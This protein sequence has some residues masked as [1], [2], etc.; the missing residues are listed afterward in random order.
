MPPEMDPKEFS[1][2]LRKHILDFIQRMERDL[3]R[4]EEI[5][6]QSA[7]AF[8]RLES[9]NAKITVCLN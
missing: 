6:R 3:A 8:E 9:Q 1:S 2:E 5:M 7:Q 4:E